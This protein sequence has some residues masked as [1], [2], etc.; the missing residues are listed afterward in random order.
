MVREVGVTVKPPVVPLFANVLAA[1]LTEP[2]AIKASLVQQVT[3]TVRWRECVAAIAATGVSDLYEAGSGKVL[4]GLAKR[5]VP[6]L[7]AVSLGTPAEIEAA[8]PVLMKPML[9]N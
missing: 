4:A 1:P 9:S 7:N 3:A 2:A 5:I 8:L 6:S